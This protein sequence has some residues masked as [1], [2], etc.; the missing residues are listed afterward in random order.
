M[1]TTLNVGVSVMQLA[2][3]EEKN[4]YKKGGGGEIEEGEETVGGGGRS[5]C[6]TSLRGE[7]SERKRKDRME[8]CVFLGLEEARR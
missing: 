2:A 3:E 7:K 4:N 6:I 8:G 5:Y 1:S